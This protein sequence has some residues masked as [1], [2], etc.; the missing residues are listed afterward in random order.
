MTGESVPALRWRSAA[1]S[2]PGGATGKARRRSNTALRDLKDLDPELSCSSRP[3]IRRSPG[4]GC[5]LRS[6]M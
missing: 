6:V 1:S 3:H 4:L 2:A 5:P